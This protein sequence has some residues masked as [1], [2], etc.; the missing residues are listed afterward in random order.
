M[1][2]TAVYIAKSRTLKR[3]RDEV[4]ALAEDVPQLVPLH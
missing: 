4:L 1:S 2:V 3:L